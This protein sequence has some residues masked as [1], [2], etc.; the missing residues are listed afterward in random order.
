MTRSLL[1]V[2]AALSSI[3]SNLATQP[4]ADPVRVG[5]AVKPPAKIKDARPVY[6]SEAQAAR[7]TGVVVIE[8]TIGE[9][10]LVRNAAV[11]RSIPMLDQAALDCV[12]QWQY[13]PTFIAGRPVPVLMTVTVNFAMQGVPPPPAPPPAPIRLL[14][15]GQSVWDIPFDRAK[16]LPRWNLESESPSVSVADARERARAWQARRNPQI[17]FE[18][19]TVMLLRMRRGADVDFWY[20]QVGFSPTAPQPAMQPMRVVVLPDGTI[21]EPTVATPDAPVPQGAGGTPTAGV[22]RPGAGITVPRLLRQVQP[23]YTDAARRAKI[24][25]TVLVEAVIGTDGVPRSMRI[26]RSLDDQFGLD[27]EALKAA[28]QWRFEPGTR[29]GQPVPVMVTLEMTFVVR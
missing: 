25:G 27:Q 9:D 4:P 23:N 28:A 26:I 7:V 15:F 1:A 14:G 19:N 20:Y 3:A 22:Y 8:V 29:D 5:G 17:A 11:Q 2:L 21:L 6:P 18:L 10:G 12:R 13:E 16:G 24:A